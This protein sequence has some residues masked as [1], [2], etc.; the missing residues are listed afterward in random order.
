MWQT[1]FVEQIPLT[2]KV[3]RTVLVYAFIIVLF[4][5]SGK[6]G[7]A[8]L[9]T[10][11]FVVLF[12]LSNVVQNAV[13]GDDQSLVGGVVGG[14]TLVSV[15]AVVTRLVDRSPRV[16]QLLE[17]RPTTLIRDGQV[18]AGAMHKLGIRRGELEH[19]VRTQNGD[20][21]SEVQDGRLVPGGHLVLTLKDEE[22]S[23]TK[24]DIISLRQQLHRVEALLVADR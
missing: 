1:L 12:L 2:E 5:V 7:L 8:T 17:S 21:I 3:L 14:V 4:R 13:I 16:Q 18:V 6:R 22:Q 23:A 9:N 15:N 24:A 20:D 10:F 19:A 11:D